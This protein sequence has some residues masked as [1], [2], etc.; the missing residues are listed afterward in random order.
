MSV[1]NT[2]LRDLERRGAAPLQVLPTLPAALAAT[3]AAPAAA[4]AEPAKLRPRVLSARLA[5]L[6]TALLL[7]AAALAG[8]L[9]LWHRPAELAAPPVAQAAATA[10]APAI[11][12][13]AA[14]TPDGVTPVVAT[15]PIGAPA[16]AAPTVAALAVA[17]PAVAT[18]GPAPA[19]PVAELSPPVESAP[20]Q[21]MHPHTATP[22]LSASRTK[23][24][25]PKSDPGQAPGSEAPGPAAAMSPSSGQS[26][27]IRATELIAHGQS[28]PAA[29]LLASALLRRPAWHEARSMLVA[30]QAERG[31]RRQALTTLL[32]GTA[33]D[34][35][36]FALTGAQLQAELNDPNGAV[37]TLERVPQAA[38]DLEF[39]ALL[40]AIAQRAGQHELAVEQ[41]GAVL[42]SEPTRALAWVGLGLSLQA[43]GRDVQA[44][45]AFRG[46]SQG[47]LSADL[48]RFVDSR[49]T[50]LQSTATQPVAAAPGRAT[51]LA[52]P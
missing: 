23:A 25:K 26:E 33:I 5:T 4:R 2:M 8:S 7:A 46:A 18:P 52:E 14:A 20:V 37:Q 38:R 27:L 6:L 31:D 34:P 28:T 3:P 13:P 39:H 12:A 35:G 21:P 1:L 22:T 45:A 41:Y 10:P 47:L 49:I 50:T 15:L 11:A 42:K 48:R 24:P 17:T 29:Q 51:P 9:W 19:A 43:L 16:A 30:L 32:D 36:R 44:L 40:A